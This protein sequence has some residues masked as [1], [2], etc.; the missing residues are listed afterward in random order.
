M[1]MFL[2][3]GVSLIIL[4]VTLSHALLSP[5]LSQDL[6]SPSLC[7]FIHVMPDVLVLVSV[8]VSGASSFLLLALLAFQ[9]FLF[10]CREEER[11]RKMPKGEH[12]VVNEVEQKFQKLLQQFLV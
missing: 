11:E 10:S 5:L 4:D 1:Y 6:R 12:N 2:V 9:L 7:S 8:T 3:C